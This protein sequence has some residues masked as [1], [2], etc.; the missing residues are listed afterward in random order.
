[1]PTTQPADANQ[2]VEAPPGYI[3]KQELA[4][5]L[6]KTTKTVERWMQ[7]GAIPYM[8]I[9]T[10]RRATVLFR[11]DVVQAHLESKFGVNMA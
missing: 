10:G 5:R 3:Q 2:P 7:E 11:W 9:G 1:M 8:K 6:C 4:R